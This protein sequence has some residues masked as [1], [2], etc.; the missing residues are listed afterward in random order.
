M[1]YCEQAFNGVQQECPSLP[2]LFVL[3]SELSSNKIRQNPK[4]KKSQA[5]KEPLERLSI[6]STADSK[7]Q[8]ELLI[9]SSFLLIRK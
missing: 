9:L 7:R 8:R 2:Y 1:R 5:L 6:T 4:L 3:S